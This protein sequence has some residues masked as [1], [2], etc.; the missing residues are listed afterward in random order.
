LG[1]LF[2][3]TGFFLFILVMLFPVRAGS[4]RTV[5]T[6]FAVMGISTFILFPCISARMLALNTLPGLMIPAAVFNGGFPHVTV[7]AVNTVY[8]FRIFETPFLCILLERT[9]IIVAEHTIM[10]C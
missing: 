2:C 5:R 3:F 6:F 9:V 4:D 1:L 10:G 8:G 7:S